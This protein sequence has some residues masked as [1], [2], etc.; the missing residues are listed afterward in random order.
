MPRLSLSTWSIH[1]ALGPIYAP[2]QDGHLTRNAPDIGAVNLLD[3]PRMMAAQGVHALEICHFHFPSTAASYLRALRDVLDTAGVEIFSILIDAGDLTNADAHQREADLSWIRSWLDVASRLG[4]PHARVIAGQTDIG[5]VPMADLSNHPVIRISADGLRALAAFGRERGVRVI[6]ENFHPLTN[7]PENILAILD[8]CDGAVGLCT[9][10]GNFRG[11][12]KYDA[13]A[14]ILP[15]ADSVHAKANFD[16]DCAIDTEDF[17]RCLNLSKA[18][19]F[20]GPYSLIYEGTGDEWAGVAAIME[21]VQG[22][23]ER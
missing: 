5:P 21:V 11:P 13:L 3:V 23:V 10:F 14:A 12:T 2:S 4:A 8:L 15:H 18:A 9:D 19:A 16:A 20:D 6:T 1:R 7:R 17:R 22:Y